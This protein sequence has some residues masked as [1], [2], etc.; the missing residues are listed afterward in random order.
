MRPIPCPPTWHLFPIALCV[1]GCQKDVEFAQYDVL[2]KK[3][4][5]ADLRQIVAPRRHFAQTIVPFVHD[6]IAY[7]THRIE[8]RHFRPEDGGVN[9]LFSACVDNA[10]LVLR[11]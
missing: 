5:A 1:L 6:A 11:T 10:A 9:R 8:V 2:A 7:D 3:S 4:G